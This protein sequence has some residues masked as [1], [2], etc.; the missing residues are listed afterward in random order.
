MG[1]TVSN[2]IRMHT[3]Y[4]FM[5]IFM[6][7]LAVTTTFIGNLTPDI[8]EHYSLNY[9]QAGNINLFFQIG[10]FASLLLGAF[11]SDKT[12]KSNIIIAAAIVMSAGLCLIGLVPPYVFLLVILFALGMSTQI[13]NILTSGYTCDIVCAEKQSGYVTFLL[14]FYSI[15][16]T[17][18]SQLSIRLED[19]VWTSRFLIIGVA[20]GVLSLL[21]LASKFVLKEP[22]NIAVEGTVE[23]TTETNPYSLAHLGKMLHNYKYFLI[24]I[25]AFLYTGHQTTITMWFPTYLTEDLE[26]SAAFMG[27]VI[28]LYWTGVLVGRILYT[29]VFKKIKAA[30]FIMITSI[31]GS[32]LLAAAIISGTQ[33]LW[34]IGVAGLGILT[35]ALFP[36]FIMLGCS[37]FPKNSGS[38][39][40]FV[41]VAFAL[42]SALFPYMLGF[43]AEY[44]ELKI[45]IY[46]SV[47]A[48]LVI[49]ILIPAGRFNR[50][51]Q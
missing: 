36:L 30:T 1:K 50:D 5:L 27:S 26:F 34:Q 48:L 37:L 22:D 18:A 6:I 4:I 49:G 35:G 13:L 46:I 17:V 20:S 33:L 28:S 14:S 47:L 51:T 25:M 9:S 38:A 23:E 44:V 39:S 21:F 15:G 32:V 31:L 29:F 45:D 40:S 42:G 19:Y 8:I 7:A 3:F 11:F 10:G 24:L 12:K 43:V 2:G 41:G 16:S